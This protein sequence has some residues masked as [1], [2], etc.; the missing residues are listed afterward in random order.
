MSAATQVWTIGHSNH[1]AADFVGL[2]EGRD[3]KVLAD[4]RS[5]PYSKY[6]SHFSQTPLRQLL[7]KAGLHYLYLGRELGGRPPE[8][9]LYD[10]DGHVLYG[11]LAATPRFGAGLDR[12]RAAAAGR[13]VAIMC[14]EEDP[15]F[16]HRRLLVARAMLEQDPASSVTHIRGDGSVVDEAEL[17]R[18]LGGNQQLALFKEADP[19]RSARSVSPSTPQRV[20]SGS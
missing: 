1:S 4:V 19:W 20:S 13:R 9:E 16:C 11:E 17:A 5:H 8:R 18:A 15:S 12:L 10:S 3:I 14:S 7:A 2:L 6:T